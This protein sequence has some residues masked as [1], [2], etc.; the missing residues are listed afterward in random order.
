[1]SLTETRV[2]KIG[3]TVFKAHYGRTQKWVTCPDCL[4]T[5]HV[6]VVLGDETAIVIEC[7]GCSR[8]WEGPH[9][10]IEQYEYATEAWEHAVTGVCT[11]ADEVSYEL[12][13]FGGGSYWT[14]KAEEVFATK[15]DALAEGE[16]R[17]KEHEDDENRRFMA[18]TKDHKSWAWNANYH[19]R[20]AKEHERQ[21]EYHR[22]RARVCAAKSKEP[23]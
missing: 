19:R 22:Q 14:A 11:H 6:K 1:M 21:L 17:R 3:D 18:K 15:E 5:K 13:R 23:T 16:R 20:Q 9:G 12:D 2:F 7:P 10:V 8:G 4:G